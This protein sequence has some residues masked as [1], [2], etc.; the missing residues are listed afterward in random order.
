MASTTKKGSRNKKPKLRRPVV[1]TSVAEQA[2]TIAELRQQLTE[3]LQRENATA[4]E[5]H[6]AL[7]QQ[8]A[9]SE[10]L[11]VIASSPTGFQMVMDTIAENAARLCEADDILVRRTDGVTYETVSHFGSIP[12]S[13]DRIP[14]EI[15]SGPG[16]AILERRI[17]H[18]HDVQEAESEF[19]GTKSYAI[20]QGIR[21]ALAVPL[22]REEIP[23][24][25]IHL[26]RLKV[27]PFTDKQIALLKTFADQAVIAIENVRLFQELRESLEQQTATSEILGVIASSPTDVQP[28]M[29]VLAENAARLCEGTDAVIFRIEGDTLQCMANYGPMPVVEMPRP[30]IR[31]S[32]GG[33]A[34]VDRQTIHVQDIAAEVETE[35]P[36]YKHIQQRTGTRTVLATPLLREGVPIG[37]IF[38]RRTEVRPF[39]DKQIALLNT[40]ADQAVIAIENVRL[41]KEIQERNAELREALEH[42]TATAEVLGIISRSPTDVQPVLD[43]IVESAARVCGMEYLTLRLREGSVTVPRAHFGSM[44]TARGEVSIDEPHIRWASEHG[45][46]HVPDVLA[47]TDFPSLGSRSDTR[48]FLAVPLRQKGQF[49][50]G[51]IA[52]RTEVRPF[53]PA[54]I[55]LLE[56]FGDQAV[57]AIENVRLFQELT[58]ALE[59]Q[60]ATSEILSVI[61][62][63]PTD[64]Q[65]VLDTI[66]ASAA[67]LCES[68]DAQIYRVE[69]DLLRKVASH[70]IVPPVLAVG[71]TRPINRTWLIDRAILQREPVHIHDSLAVLDED[72][73][74]VRQADERLGVR[75]CLAVP[76]L[77]EGVAV[78]AILIRRTEVRP[79]TDKQITLL[80]TFAHQAVIAIENV[81]LF[82]ELQER[83]RD[84]TEALEQQTATGEVLR[85]IASSPTNLQPVL[86][87]VIANAVKLVGATQGHIRRYDGEFLRVVAHYGATS[88][89]IA[90]LQSNPIRVVPE[91]K[92]GGRVLLEKKVVHVL[93]AQAEPASYPL[94]LQRG[95]R[96]LLGV[97]LL[98]EET[99]I[100]SITIW[101][102]FVDGFTEQQIELIKTFA[103]QA[104]IAIE[105]VRLFNELETRNRD[106]SEALEQQTA[107]SEILRVIASSPTDI[108]PVLDVVAE[109]AARLCDAID[110]V[111]G[112]PEGDKLRIVAKYG[113]VPVPDRV[114]LTREFPAGRAVLDRKTIHIHDILV[115]IEEYPAARAPQQ[116]TGIRT[117]LNTPLL[118][119]NVAIGFIAVRRTEV[120]PF[121]DKQIALLKT[122]ADQAVIAI[123]N[124]RLFKELQERNAELR[125]ALE[126]QTATAEV[127][128][129]ISRS[130][131]DVQPVLDAIVESATRVCGIDDVTLRLREDNTMVV[132][133]HFGSIPI[134]TDRLEVSIDEPHA[135]WMREHGTLHIP[136]VTEQNDFR[137]VSISARTF[138]IVPLRQQGEIIGTLTARRTEVRPFTP[139]QI[140]LL[141][142]F[143]DQAVIAIENVRLFQE[144]KESLEQQ[145]ATSEILG[146][147][148]S[149]PTDIQ[150][151]LD[152]VA[153]NA[154]KLC[155]AIDAVILRPEGDSLRVLAK[156]G[157]I[158]IASFLPLSRDFPPGR[159]VIDRQTIHI[160][161]VKAEIDTEYPDSRVPQQITGVRTVLNT[162]L[163]KE[164]VAIGC[165]GVRRT[166]VRPFTE[167]QIAL[168]KT[169]ADQAVI[170]IENVRLFKELQERNAELREALEHQTATAE[171]LA[172]ISRSPTDVQPV[173]DAIVESAARVCGIDDVVLRFR[174]GNNLVP[175]AHYGSVPIRNIE[176][177]IDAPPVR[178]VREHGT[179]HIPDV[180]AQSDIPLV[181]PG[182]LRTFLFVPLRQKR[183]LVG[184]LTARR[185]EVRPFIPAQMKL[186]ETFAN[187]AVIAIENVR[188][189]QELK[190]SLEQQTATS[191]ILGAIASSPTDI[192]PVLDVVAQNAA[193]LCDASDAAIWRAEGDRFWLV[194]SHGSIPILRPEE[195][196]SMTRGNY[197]G[198]VLIDRETVHIH[199]ILSP[200]S[201]LEFPEAFRS[202]GVRTVLVTPLLREGVAIGAIHV[203]RPQIRPFFD[204]QI[205]LLKT[206]ASQGVIAI[207]NVRLFKELQERNAEL[208]E[209]LEHQTATA[210]VLGI[211]SRSP[212]DVQPVLDAIVQSAARVCGI[213]DVHLRL[214][215]GSMLVSRA[216]FGPIPVVHGE[217]DVDESNFRWMRDHGTLHIPD[218][219]A[220]NDFP[221]LGARHYLRTFLGVPLRQ[222][223]ELIGW[224]A[225]RRTDVHP[226]TPAQ[227][228]LL[229]TFADQAVIALENVRLFREL[230]EALEQQTATSEILGVIASSPTDI[231]PVLDAI[232]Q[233]AARVCG[234]DDAT[235][236]L[237]EGNEM[238]LAA[239]FGTIPPSG[240]GRRSLG[241][242]SVGNEALLQRR[243]IHIPDLQ[244][245]TERFPDSVKIG[246]GIR[247]FLVTPLLR[248]GTAIGLINI[249]RTEVKPFTD[250]QVALLETFASQA[251]IAIENVRLFQELEARTRQLAQS[252]GELKALGEVGQAVSSTLDLQTVLSTIVGRAVQLSGTDCGIIYEYDEATQEFHLRASYQMEHELVDAYQATP[253]RLGQG[254]TGRAAQTRVPYQIAD[255]REEHELATRGM[256]PI[257]SR[258]GYRSLLAVPLL[259][260]QKIM[261][262][263]TIYRRETGSFAPEIVNL[264]RTFATQSVLAI[265][266]A[267]L[268]REI[269]DKSRQIEAANR[270]KSE[271]LANMSHELRT[272]LNAII[273]FSEVLSERMFGDLNEKQ[274]EYT[275]DIL[276]SGR[277]LLSLI[278]EILDLSKVEAGRMELELTT[279]DLPLAIDNARTF[280]RERATKHG[281]NLEVS[282]DE[283]LGDYV[284]DER[285]IKQILL[286]LLSNA[287]KFTPEGG[288]IGIEAKQADGSIEI[289]VSDTGIGIAP[290]DQPK[291]FEEFRQVGSDYAHKTEGTGL[292]LTLA[293]KF[294]ELHGGKI[295]VESEVGKSSR[296][297]F[298]LPIHSG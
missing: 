229:E 233:S 38:I 267:R 179:L 149:S 270:H 126:H 118:R 71:E 35:F 136:D 114:P 9:T 103:D 154:A 176:I 143:A 166:E 86:D 140:K 291:I 182:S 85:V 282:V 173:L 285:K 135:R 172:I 183:E 99:P 230:K 155:D 21:T 204:K 264:L 161:D 110:G 30:I 186:L 247:T 272:P 131:T 109:N 280:V 64:I 10:I 165:I 5:L 257:L 108:Q 210:E 122:F 52:R 289:S 242:R 169:F 235:I 51:L 222:Q 7:E 45:T 163:L 128:G 105:N 17:V 93:D 277:H 121:T 200:E 213:D 90:L 241:W 138:L 261:G 11:R 177:G 107:T 150:P 224:L 245:E 119:E 188:L 279:F 223:G 180:R 269:E 263:L 95:A 20:P 104:V 56:T 29:N 83:N 244:A 252:V 36:E 74:A 63:S 84:L 203:R 129:I 281:I 295:W 260:D 239:H 292:G 101:R 25:V 189:F 48:T 178:W 212:T 53:T 202:G 70:G 82:K 157:A 216:H 73:A 46:L 24:G 175:K 258:L 80:K 174:E 16:R 18:I 286:N 273:G 208:R 23:I 69:N 89:Q 194:A 112:L 76:L 171:V 159:A 184:L 79:F 133:A 26:R 152:V 132:R 58:Q 66:A 243:T 221:M 231:Q 134:P 43:A 287:V 77:R 162:P 250:K 207:E 61:A 234:S 193:R 236:R 65:P 153:E 102:N 81:R 271:F 294:V 206:F 228:K 192:Q 37:V 240:P 199:D 205:A 158:P 106:L 197:V 254:A 220:Q 293:K 2:Q 100:G 130:P 232:A 68:Q 262:A 215:A 50:G 127:L 211:I 284:G 116:L 296:F 1:K 214:K 191:G 55:K 290:Q 96:T 78:G 33:R 6:E 297:T 201:L 124:V 249:R 34:V 147:I 266:N 170:A 115:E 4:K 72:Y 75:T 219:S 225:A 12:H 28:V 144:L 49:I 87:T 8:T 218:I 120:R 238:I 259:L 40:F 123:E 41:F 88:E 145:T 268:F 60:T 251:V 22:L 288:R 92:F 198:R 217:I 209:A 47:Q 15:G 94:A 3:S 141:E 167:K 187:Q 19:P 248:E 255:L 160:H 168:L 283:R 195:P 139:A 151:V 146:V 39:T 278:N 185:A 57:I 253:L 62:S 42:Q 190:E 164:G 97:P 275:D 226:F 256:R 276:T 137:I 98:R 67:R 274:A 27:L 111:I 125:E 148:A 31:G 142:T 14:V 227:I 298:T 237:L 59:Q 113:A 117:A 54:Q 44:P 13:G 91:N 196:R 181:S 32:P 265:Q 156:Y 246:P